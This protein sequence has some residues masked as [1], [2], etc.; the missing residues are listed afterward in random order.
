MK[1][2]VVLLYNGVCLEPVDICYTE[3]EASL[4]AEKYGGK[5]VVEEV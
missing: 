3:V 5:A 2:F 1:M 4:R